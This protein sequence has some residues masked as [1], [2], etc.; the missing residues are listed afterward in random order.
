MHSEKKEKF[1]KIY[2]ACLSI[3]GLDIWDR[4]LGVGVAEP[5]PE[6]FPD[7]LALHMN[8]F[9]LPEFLPELARLE[10]N[11]HQTISNGIE[12][13]SEIGELCVNPTVR[14]LQLSWKNLF[15]QG[16]PGDARNI[17]RHGCGGD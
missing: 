5:E 13:P 14:L 3:L 8:N 10:W 7:T 17:N 1:E 11:L 2:R 15:A 9:G 12:L 4:F 16:C 6:S